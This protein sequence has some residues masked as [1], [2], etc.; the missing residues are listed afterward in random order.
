MPVG[1]E[2]E[3]DSPNIEN[4]TT[5]GMTW[6]E[7][8]EWLW[9]RMD[10]EYWE[11]QAAQRRADR[12]QDP[13]QFSGTGISPTPGETGATGAAAGS[14]TPT[15]M[16]YGPHGGAGMPNPYGAA[17][18]AAGGA[19]TAAAGG[20][21]APYVGAFGESGIPW[22]AAATEAAKTGLPKWAD[23]LIQL[24]M[25]FAAEWVTK[26]SSS[27]QR[28]YEEAI[29]LANEAGRMQ[30]DFAKRLIS[31]WGAMQD[32]INSKTFTGPTPEQ[33]RAMYNGPARG[34]SPERMK[35]F[36]ATAEYMASKDFGYFAKIN[37]LQKNMG[38]GIGM[39]N[40]GA[41]PAAA[42]IQLGLDQNRSASAAGLAQTGMNIFQNYKN[43]SW[44]QDLINNY[45]KPRG[46]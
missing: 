17:P 46:Q 37:M 23:F 36:D 1:F 28:A 32:S 26:P 39:M 7:M 27:E 42:N 25:P 30:I 9:S 41:V 33:L 15:A 43:Q 38:L 20:T 22:A 12:G 5:D 2:G 10:D 24:G 8:M 44:I 11:E 31:E 34:V 19:G 6:D 35:G 40:P 13:A 18:T 21:T 29:G 14:E 3:G 4:K 16:G 45:T